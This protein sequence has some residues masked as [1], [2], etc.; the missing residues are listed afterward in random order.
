[1]AFVKLDTG[2]LDSTLWIARSAREV[3]ITALL[4]ARPA[5]LREPTPALEVERLEPSG[6]TVPA[7]WYGLVEAAGIAIVRRAIVPDDE[8]IAALVQLCAPE[9]AS[10]SRA[11]DGR[12]LARVDGGFLVLNWEAYRTKD[13]TAADR[14]A[15]YRQR[16]RER[17][18]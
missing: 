2:I 12:R 17:G 15:R 10:R 11:H 16:Q 8:G 4:M 18:A 5:E 1:M 7:G 13:H 9:A 14:S 3:F 6:F